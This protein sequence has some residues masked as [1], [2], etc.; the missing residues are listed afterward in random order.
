MAYGHQSSIDR[1]TRTMREII[2]ASDPSRMS[3]AKEPQMT[4]SRVPTTL[5]HLGIGLEDYIHK[6]DCGMILGAMLEPRTVLTVVKD[7]MET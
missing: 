3:M 6:L 1:G 7:T 4:A 5:A 2:P